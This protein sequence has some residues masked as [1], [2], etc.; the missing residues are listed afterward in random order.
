MLPVVFSWGPS[1]S[2]PYHFGRNAIERQTIG[3]ESRTS[4]VEP[5]RD[6][7]IKRPE[8]MIIDNYIFYDMNFTARKALFAPVEPPSLRRHGEKSA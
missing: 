4:V 8:M 2:L 5:P 6:C 7:L 1:H 3:L